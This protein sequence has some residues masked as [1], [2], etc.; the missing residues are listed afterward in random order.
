MASQK[1]PITTTTS[2]F[3]ELLSLSSNE[4]GNEEI[5]KAYRTMALKYHPDVCPDP[6]CTKVFVLLNTAYKTLSNPVLRKEYD[7]KMHLGD[8]GRAYEEEFGGGD[9][10][11]RWE[12]QVLELKRRSSFRTAKKFKTTPL[13]NIAVIASSSSTASA[14][15]SG[16]TEPASAPSPGGSAGKLHFF[17][18]PELLEAAKVEEIL[19]ERHSAN[20]FAAEFTTNQAG[21]APSFQTQLFLLAQIFHK[22][23]AT[24]SIL[25]LVRDDFVRFHH[26]H[27]NGTR[28]LGMFRPDMCQKDS[29]IG[30]EVNT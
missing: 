15:S 29:A 16:A 22:I 27:K 25:A 13:N 4:V 6:E 28:C 3:Y 9:L 10:R 11:G 7:N 2:S 1:D 14:P 8:F 23:A 30:Q 19:V 17:K 5:K 12:D 18:L 20:V 21:F 26:C 24:N